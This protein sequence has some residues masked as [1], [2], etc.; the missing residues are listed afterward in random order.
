LDFSVTYAD[1]TSTVCPSVPLIG[2]RGTI[3]TPTPSPAVARASFLSPA[4]IGPSI[5]EF[6]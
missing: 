6:G 2:G 4:C 3:V 5:C 1:G